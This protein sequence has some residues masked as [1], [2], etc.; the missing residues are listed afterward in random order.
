M[1]YVNVDLKMDKRSLDYYY[2]IDV[3]SLLKSQM[4]S[5]DLDDLKEEG[6]SFSEDR[7]KIILYITT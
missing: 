4:P 1:R 5:N 7:K 2:E 3:D 6:W